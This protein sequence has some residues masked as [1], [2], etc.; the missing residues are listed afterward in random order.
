MNNIILSATQ[1]IAFSKYVRGEN[2]FITGPGGC[3]KSEL[4]RHIYNDAVSRKKNISVCAL[5]GCAASLLDCNARTI[6]SW[7]GIGLANNDSFRINKLSKQCKDRWLRTDILIIDEISMMSIDLF[8][9]LNFVAMYVRKTTEYFGG[10]QLI[11][12]GDFFQLPP[13]NSDNFCFE[14]E[15]WNDIFNKDNQIELK[16][17]FRQTD[18]K[19]KKLLNQI[20]KGKLFK[21]SFNLLTT[22]MNVRTDNLEI[23]PII[24]H[25]NKRQV[26]YLNNLELKKINEEEK[27]YS[28]NT[29]LG[30]DNKLLK[31]IKKYYE[32]NNEFDKLNIKQS[33]LTLEKERLSKNSG[34][35]DTLVLKKGAKVMCTV[36]YSETFET[37]Q[38]IYNGCQGI[39][40]DFTEEDFPIVKFTNGAVKTI[41][42]HSWCSDKYPVL[43]IMQIPLILAWAITIHKSQ[44]LSLDTANLYIGDDIFEAGQIY[45]AIS[46][47]RNIDGLYLNEFNHSKIKAN[48]KVIEFYHQLSKKG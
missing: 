39:I 45:V 22:R 4:I 38:P 14:S 30:D 44:G 23:T 48:K 17:I 43:N 2:I 34:F 11:F 7:A 21:N 16:T 35:Y 10:I 41:K 33:D 13:V 12:S 26:E 15:I 5:T 46:R 32:S 1:E 40:I 19:Y 36:N 18:D 6:H 42:P 20:R 28:S 8:Q 31:E 9:I 47:V 3:G 24:L 25:S 27:I 37:S 29:S